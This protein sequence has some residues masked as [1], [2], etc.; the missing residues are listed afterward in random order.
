V[1]TAVVD[2]RVLVDAFTPL[3][4]DPG[5]IAADARIAAR[6]LASRAILC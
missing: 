3:H 6:E 2:G 1:R 5:Q 4:V